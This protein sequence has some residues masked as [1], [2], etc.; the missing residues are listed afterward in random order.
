[1]RSYEL[2]VF[3]NC[4]FDAEYVSTQR[5]IV[6]GVT[7]CGFRVRCALEAVDSARNRFERIC[8]LIRECRLG[9]HDL[10]RTRRV[11]SRGIEDNHGD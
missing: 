5:A 6:F 10:P 3:L 1:M 7:A 4:P 9:I 8:Q 11:P 2:D